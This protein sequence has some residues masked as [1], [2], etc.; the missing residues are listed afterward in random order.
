MKASRITFDTTAEADHNTITE[1][2]MD[3][4][5]LK[6]SDW[7]LIETGDMKGANII[8]DSRTNEVVQLST[9]NCKDAD[10]WTEMPSL[11]EYPSLE[12]VNLESSRY[13]KELHDSITGLSKLRTLVLTRCLCLERLP[14]SFGRLESL[15]EVGSSFPRMARP[16][17]P[18]AG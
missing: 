17:T 16:C 18:L 14:V 1:D 4:S 12:I 6:Q 3:D 15:Q 11:E 7:V 13:I 8:I 5:S 2:T 10:R 9:R